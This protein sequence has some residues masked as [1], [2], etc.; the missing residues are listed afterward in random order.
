MFKVN[1]LLAAPL[2]SRLATVF[3][4]LHAL[5]LIEVLDDL[6]IT[7]DALGTSE[8]LSAGQLR[9]DRDPCWL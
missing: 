3:A 9:A 5:L 4:T 7:H 1:D 8:I 2:L 6:Q